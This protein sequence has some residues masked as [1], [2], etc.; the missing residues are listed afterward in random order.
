MKKRIKAPLIAA[1]CTIT[2]VIILAIA[3]VFGYFIN[4]FFGNPISKHLATKT[5][6]KQ[7]ASCY[8]DTDYI[9][10]DVRYSLKDGRYYAYIISPASPDSA[11]TLYISMLGKIELD[12]HESRVTGRWNTAM[13]I[14]AEYGAAVD[15][16]IDGEAF[17]YNVDIGY[18]ALL[19][20]RDVSLSDFPVGT[21]DMTSLV[22]DGVYAP[23]E[24]GKAAG[25]I[26]L[27][28]KGEAVTEERLAEILLDIKEIFDN[29][30]VAFNSINLIL[31]NDS[32]DE[33]VEVMSMLYTDIYE[34]GFL[35]RVK[36]SNSAAKEYYN[37]QNE[38][39]LK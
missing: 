8:A 2:A 3:L 34:D 36:Q 26:T 4:G 17:P 35:E 33:R 22:L 6:E 18:G 29:G 14:D 31:E 15:R 10:D 9:I 24:T 39:K 16:I 32:G 5:A 19:F 1:I 38:E 25:E 23:Y 30:A 21:Y 12:D 20:D 7:L 37:K 13:R 27:Y 11:F 28:I